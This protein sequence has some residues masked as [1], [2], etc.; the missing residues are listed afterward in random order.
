MIV[1]SWNCGGLGNSYAVIVLSHLVGEKAPN[2]LFLM[3]T[4]H[5]VD[6]M[7]LIQAELHYD[8]V[9]AVP[10][11]HRAAGLAML[12]KEQ[13]VDLHVQNYTKNHIDAH[14]RTNP[15]APWRIT[16]F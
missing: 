9:F 10:C 11:I 12:W 1:L 16:S 2:F 8:G 4:K 13:K 3:E 7:K 5:T 15:S 6:E 14:I